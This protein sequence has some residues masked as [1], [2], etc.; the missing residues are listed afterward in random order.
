MKRV[1]NRFPIKMALSC[2]IPAEKNPQFPRNTRIYK[3]DFCGMNFSPDY[4]TK[5]KQ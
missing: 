1:T 4:Q 2:I 5:A 3:V